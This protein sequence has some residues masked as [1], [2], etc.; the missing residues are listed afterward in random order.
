MIDNLV[1]RQKEKIAVLHIQDRAQTCQRRTDA[2][3][4]TPCFGDW[5]VDELISKFLFQ[6]EG[7][8]IGRAQ[9]RDRV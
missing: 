7:D 1:H 8:E 3:T 9:V 4:D 6:S 2:K 5:R